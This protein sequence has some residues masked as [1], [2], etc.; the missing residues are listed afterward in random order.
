MKVLLWGLAFFILSLILN[1]FIWRV[2]LPKRQTNALL[3]IFYGVFVLGI[4][5]FEV[6]K[7]FNDNTSYQFLPN[8]IPEY[9]HLFLLFTSLSLAYIIT[10]SAV[11]VD[12]PSLVMVLAVNK[13]GR[14]GLSKTEFAELLTNERL[15]IPRINDLVRDKL[16]FLNRD[17]YKLTSNGRLF[18]SIFILY[19]KIMNA[20][21]G[22]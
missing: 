9:L 10:Y 22:G 7:A 5:L 19:R 13:A 12:S 14:N 2:R 20:Q 17:K 8:G 6:S 11:E 16:I 18:I 1:L 21:K 4:I 15:V 3:K